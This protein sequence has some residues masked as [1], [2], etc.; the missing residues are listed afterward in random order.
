LI[1]LIE[2]CDDKTKRGFNAII[3]LRSCN[4]ET[5]TGFGIVIEFDIFY[6]DKNHKKI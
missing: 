3:K 4:D 6:D 5:K 1:V 2:V